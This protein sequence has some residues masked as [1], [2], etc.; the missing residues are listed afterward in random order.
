M[1]G[2]AAAGLTRRGLL[3]IGGG[4]AGVAVVGVAG[5]ELATRSYPQTGTLLTSGIPL[6]P[7]FTRPLPIPE[8]LAPTSPGAGADVYDLLIRPGTQELV[9]G[10]QTE[11]WGFGGTFPGPTIRASSGRT[12]LVRTSNELPIPIVTHLHGGVV[13]TASDGYP[14]DLLMPL[15][16][17]SHAA[18]PAPATMPGMPAMPGMSGRTDPDALIATGSR[19]YTY[20]NNQAAATL[21]Y[22]DHR[23]GFTAPDLWRGLAGFYLVTDPTE[24]AL[25]LPAGAR[26]I[27][28]MITDRAFAAD[29]SLAYPSVD[30]TLLQT[31]GVTG[32]YMSGV[33]GDVILVNG[34][35]W[36]YLEVDRARYRLRLLN[37]SNARRHQLALSPQPPGGGALVQVGSDVGLLGAPLAHDAIEIAQAE[38]FD[39]VVDFSRYR[40]GELVTLT[41][42]FGAGNTGQVMQFR[43]GGA[44]SDD[45]SV[46][47]AL[48]EY[49]ALRR[50][51]AVAT[52]S[53][54]FADVD[55]VW[56]VNGQEF[57]PAAFA[58]E[59]RAGTTEVW[60]FVTDLHH[61][62][63][64]HAAHFQVLT[65]NGKAPGAY[66]AGWKDTVDVLPAEEVEVL[67]RFP[68]LTGRYVF[69][70]HNLEHEDMAM[71]A[72]FRL[73]G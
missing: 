25:P 68:Q 66:D 34:A 18:V 51:D 13:P 35:A 46:P 53:F 1:S 70:C 71:M 9:T 43:V 15:G 30:P 44:A 58:A 69:H 19:T 10:H 16:T 50:S 22:H 28:L 26:D 5:F 38:R 45:T 42:G 6:P 8:T 41:N 73:V 3:R 20:P 48:A 12:V 57:D 49:R 63:H 31:P 2:D 47:A 40:P 54:D 60:R 14:T 23:M 67:V 27:P 56:K 55:G 64:L 72:N 39:V 59:P 33:L 32:S 52:R 11:I 24:Q 29:G 62:I 36:P 21:W 65:R 37:A 61:P 7:L 4:V 17:D